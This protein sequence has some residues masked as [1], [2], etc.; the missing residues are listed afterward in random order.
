MSDDGEA[1]MIGGS[2]T[3][4]LASHRTGLA[5]ERTMMG[6]DRT[7]MGI[8][9]TALALIGF[10][11]TINEVLRQLA[12]RRL[13]TDVDKTGRHV[14]AALLGLGVLFLVLG[15]ISHARF[16]FNLKQRRRRLLELRLLH[17][18]DHYRPTATFVTAAL[19][20]GVGLLALVVVVFRLRT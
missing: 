8:V 9:R 6:A 14:G 3:N 11:F 12:T 20:L 5:F 2:A 18:F 4:E 15:L 19:L 1:G 16:Y 17:G 7:L 10:G 13:L